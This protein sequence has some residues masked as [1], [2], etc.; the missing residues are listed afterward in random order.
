MQISI[1]LLVAVAGATVAFGYAAWMHRRWLLD[2][3]APS[4]AL[5][6]ARN[7]AIVDGSGEGIL[8]LA[9][10]GQVV[11]ANPA[12][13][14]M[15]GYEPHELLGSDYRRFLAVPQ[16][17]GLHDMT[18]IGY[19]TDMLRGIG[20]VLRC[21]GG[22]D[23]PIEYRMLPQRQ[24]ITDASGKPVPAATLLVFRDLTE[25]TRI[26]VMLADMQHLAQV[27]AWELKV[28]SA[29]LIVSEGISRRLRLSA[30]RGVHARHLLL[31]FTAAARGQLFAAARRAIVDGQ[32]FDLELQTRR[33]ATQQHPGGDWLRV[34]GRAERVDG[35]TVRLYGAAQDISDRKGAEVMLRHTSEFFRSTLDSLPACVMYLLP[36]EHIDYCNASP[37]S[38]WLALHEAKG[39]LLIEAL[40]AYPDVI[41]GVR[42]ALQGY[43]DHLQQ[44][45][46]RADECLQIH[47]NFIPDPPSAG[48]C[49]GCWL[50]LSDVTEM[51]LLEARLHQAE[52]LQAVGQL[53]GGVAHD[54]NNVLGV[55]L[56][57]LQLL[58][59][60]LATDE[61]ATRKLATAMRAALRGSELTRR[62][63]SFAR[64]Q[65]LELQVIDPADQL[66]SLA[67]LLQQ[68]LGDQIQIRF[69]LPDVTWCVNVDVG[70][71]ENAILNLALNARDAMA[72]GGVLT[73]AVRPI[74]PDAQFYHAH[75]D[76]ASGDY[77]EVSVADTG[78]GIPPQLLHR[79][80]EPFFTTKE[81]GKGNG[82]GLAIVHGFAKQS[83]GGVTVHS[84]TGR[85]TRVCI[86][87][88]RT[89]SMAAEQGDLSVQQQVR[90][91]NEV[92]LV[93]EDDTDLRA[94]TALALQDL[95]Y[96]VLE[97]SNGL[98]A[99]SILE[100]HDHIDMLFTDV[101]MPAGMLGTELAARARALRP[102]IKVLLTTG[103][104][105]DP[106]L[107][108]AGELQ[109]ETL[110]PKPYVNEILAQKIRALLD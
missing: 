21:K 97:A 51:R 78:K 28:G 90:G 110:L 61:A 107:A 41:H 98:G 34:M 22:R 82:L 52:K 87:L 84:E 88:P 12:A 11:F 14:R 104:L 55:I 105:G 35:V 42:Q 45:F 69:D 65:R 8:E 10:S 31:G 40:A 74:T 93:V 64:R 70:Q 73:L 103:Y 96:H 50:V 79:I 29:R 16:L 1:P 108:K 17:P 102:Q 2:H 7:Q 60:D 57:N 80:F 106:M 95:G 67:D 23:R 19:T 58:E 32:S 33:V 9:M 59:R 6:A 47:C 20:A 4:D 44:T 99:L 77:V 75:P 86:L 5:M 37:L 53:T 101:I 36:D 56:G 24:G 63:L 18:R 49:G 38:C 91:G 83:G 109:D 81:I 94:T 66:K 100:Q 46:T 27:G 26:D 85:G 92:I 13:Q 48:R 30:G 25:R 71:F 54:F 62:L 76:I 15:L 39:Q 72:Q 68:T 89:N 43:T 3:V